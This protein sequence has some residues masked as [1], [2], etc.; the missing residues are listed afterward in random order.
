MPSEIPPGLPPELPG[1]PG[2]GDAFGTAGP[3]RTPP[4]SVAPALI[5]AAGGVLLAV[6]SQAFG[7][8]ATGIALAGGFLLLV[9]VSRVVAWAVRRYELTDR[10]I[11]VT[12]GVLERTSS[13]VPYQRVQQVDLHA[14]LLQRLVG[15]VTVRVGTAGGSEG[16][17]V[18]IDA[19]N[20]RQ[21][22]H[23]RTLILYR[24][25]LARAVPGT[26]TPGARRAAAETFSGPVAAAESDEAVPALTLSAGRLALAGA[27]GSSIWLGIVVLLGAV[28]AALD[29]LGTDGTDIAGA[30]SAFSALA[31]VLLGIGLLVTLPLLGAGYAVLT[32]GGY[33][34]RV[35]PE[36]VRAE[37][38]LLSQRRLTL[39]RQRVQ[40]VTVDDNP[41]RRRL[42]MASVTVQSATVASGDTSRSSRLMVPLLTKE[43]TDWLVL[44]AVGLVVPAVELRPPAARG[45]AIRR[46]LWPPLAIGAAAVAGG[47]LTGAGWPLLVGFAV[48][49]LVLAALAVPWG[50]A[51]Y[52][53][54]GYAVTDSGVTLASGVLAHRAW[55]VPIARVQSA[56]A[57]QSPFQ[58]RRDLATF[59]LDVAG[60][61]P[62]PHLRDLGEQLS[63]TLT[64]DVPLA[65][66]PGSSPD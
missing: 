35:T 29:T 33:R 37:Y 20:P 3:E 9:G 23:V 43:E 36:H 58:A 21:A 25:D 42:G 44:A 15:L 54:G 31:L 65:S 64:H 7:G 22:E 34:L 52:R 59:S 32:Y 45:R 57:R 49:A 55:H 60:A 28:F 5:V 30:V 61:S 41:V 6:V 47:A 62:A 12:A 40:L 2:S 26:P 24:R 39:P 13:V 8:G 17:Q 1:L 27:T 51:Y 48:A 63:R 10:E 56:A 14:T 19:L 18:N 50:A 16:A 66:A 46:R 38:G 4:M 11:K 53:R